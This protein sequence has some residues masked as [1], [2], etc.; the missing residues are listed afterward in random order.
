MAREIPE[1]FK[2]KG[3][4]KRRW[5]LYKRLVEHIF[6]QIFPNWTDS[7]AAMAI[8]AGVPSS[9][10]YDW[11]VQYD[12]DANWR[13]YKTRRSQNKRLFT[14][15]EEMAIADHIAEA[16]IARGIYF[17]DE[18]FQKVAMEAWVRKKGVGQPVFSRGFVRKFKKR[19]GFVTRKAHAKRRPNTNEYAMKRW[20]RTLKNL[21]DIEPPERI[22]NIDETSWHPLPNNMRTWAAR[23]AESVQIRTQTNDKESMTVICGITAART[24]I[25]MRI[26]VKGSTERVCRSLGDI[27]PHMSAHSATG[28]VTEDVF[29]EYLMWLREYFGDDKKLHL[30]MDCYSVHRK[31]IIQS[32]ANTLNIDVMFVPPGCTDQLQ[33]LDRYVFGSL[34][35]IAKRKWRRMYDLGEREKMTKKEMAEIL[36][37][38]WE[39]VSTECLEKAWDIYSEDDEDDELLEDEEEDESDS[40][41]ASDD[42][43]E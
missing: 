22:I 10:L 21:I 4:P 42:D 24:K 36:I 43:E 12:R 19:H 30:I 8:E 33:P 14:D 28:W 34:K 38:S 13:P 18:D 6:T 39:G 7:S 31:Q 5:I 27:A 37:A 35:G 26:I 25:P 11:K 2:I 40:E 16:Y 3:P 1:E 15:E 17:T 32:L 41:E 9:T 23:G 20:K 29:S